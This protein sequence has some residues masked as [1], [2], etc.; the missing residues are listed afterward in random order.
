MKQKGCASADVRKKA[1]VEQAWLLYFNRVLFE[2][3]LISEQ[4]RNR[5][6]HRIR[7]R[8]GAQKPLESKGAAPCASPAAPPFFG[9]SI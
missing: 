3:G 1:A 7:G 9:V 6:L 8:T 2:Q 4:E 5:M